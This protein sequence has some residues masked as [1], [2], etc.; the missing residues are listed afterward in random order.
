[1][2]PGSWMTGR[3]D[4]PGLAGQA[5]VGQSPGCPGHEHGNGGAEDVS[6]AGYGDG[7]DGARDTRFC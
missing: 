2:P 7:G 1:M 6:G 5:Q 4:L 3:C